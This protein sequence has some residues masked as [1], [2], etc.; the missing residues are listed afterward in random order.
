MK[1]CYV[2]INGSIVP[3]MDARISPDDRGIL[4]GD[5]IYET[6]LVRN[7]EIIRLR[8][9]LERLKYGIKA[10]RLPEQLCEVNYKEAIEELI[11]ANGY[12][13]ARI[14]INI[15]R[16]TLTSEEPT[17]FITANELGKHKMETPRVI[18]SSYRRD[19]R[20]PLTSVKTINC[21]T[22]VMALYEARD[23][24]ADDAILLNAQGN[25]AEATTANVFIVRGKSLMTPALDQG[26]LSGTIR[27]TLLEMAPDFGLEPCE[28]EISPDMLNEADEIF[29]CSAIKLI[30]PVSEIAGRKVGE[31]IIA[32]K[33][34]KRPALI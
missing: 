27:T 18:I 23:A 24:G 4:Y 34:I 11:D 28:C 17:I 19:E 12:A 22:S 26:C 16:G 20:N 33:T 25:I 9:H 10:I 32:K 29:L 1:D 6:I 30:R 15:T 14:R 7:R 2:H 21:L 5:G 13:D 8:L 3:I 31:P